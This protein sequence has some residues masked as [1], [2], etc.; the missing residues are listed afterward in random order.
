MCH[1][2]ANS[3]QS[4]LLLRAIGFD[5]KIW[6]AD[7]LESVLDDSTQRADLFVTLNVLGGLLHHEIS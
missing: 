1:S 5:I 6:S 7:K 4:E 2:P 3:G